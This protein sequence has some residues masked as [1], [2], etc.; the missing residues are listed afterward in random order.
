[1][2][3]FYSGQIGSCFRAAKGKEFE[4]SPLFLNDEQ[5]LYQKLNGS[6]Y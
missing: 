1:V 4:W 3:F 5:K 2:L 6:G